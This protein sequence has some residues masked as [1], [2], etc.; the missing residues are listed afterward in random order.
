M[1][2]KYTDKQALFCKIYIT[3]H[4]AKKSALEAGYSKSFAEKKSYLLLK[5]EKI[6][7]KIEELESIFYKDKFAQLA[8]K[9]MGVLEEIIES[10]FLEEKV[11]LAAIKEVFK[12]YGLEQKLAI[13]DKSDK[14]SGVNIIFNEVSSRNES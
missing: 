13:N 11:R 8:Y 10:D 12:Y 7:S 5:D 6:I 3:N 9:S 14:S 1:S 4:D 2:E